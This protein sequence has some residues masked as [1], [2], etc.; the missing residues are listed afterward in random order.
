MAREPNRRKNTQTEKLIAEQLETRGLREPRLLQ[1]LREVDRQLFVPESIRDLAYEDQA[2]EISH[3][4]SISQPYIV[5]LMLAAADLRG[6]E[7]LLDV[8][9]GS[10]YAA[11]VASHLVRRVISIERIPAL[12]RSA[13][14]RLKELGYSHI[15]VQ[16]GDGTLGWPAEAPYD[17]IL[18]A[19]A[20][21]DVPSSLQD[22]LAPGGRL[23]LPVGDLDGEQRLLRVTRGRFGRS[24]TEDLGPVRF[25]PL[26]GAQGWPEES[27]D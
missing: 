5:A 10:G 15:E 18:V 17:A 3:G 1:A 22:Q 12:A 4:Q 25:V 16:I 23:V 26:I 11:A 24:R 14:A 6:D 27:R 2:L 8:G 9:T 13:A 19:A 20:A 21:P 7:L